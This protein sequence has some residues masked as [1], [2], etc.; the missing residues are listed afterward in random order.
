VAVGPATADAIL[1]RGISVDVVP[2]RFVAE[3]VLESLRARGGMAGARVLYPAAEGARPVLL[4]GLHQLGA[5]VDFIPTYRSVHEHAGGQ[6]VR[7]MIV[8]GNLDLGVFASG[9]AVRGFVDAVGGGS[10]V[11]SRLPAITIGPITSEAARAAG[12]TIVGEAADS[13]I[14]GL[15]E[16]VLRVGQ[17]MMT[18]E[19]TTAATTKTAVRGGGVGSTAVAETTGQL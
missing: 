7:E 1:E 4:E 6:A 10:E 17:R 5:T 19:T 3:A 12:L 2:D 18:G 15:V 9:A 16:E 13:T 11:A 14:D 8:G